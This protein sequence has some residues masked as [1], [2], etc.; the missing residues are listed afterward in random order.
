MRKNG[1]ANASLARKRRHRW[2]TIVCTDLSGISTVN[3][4]AFSRLSDNARA[5]IINS[6]GA[7]I[8]SRSDMV[9]LYYWAAI[10]VPRMGA[11]R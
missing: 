3:T 9:G 10:H 5:V 7:S 11:L 8:C 6:S 1:E 2:A 4:G